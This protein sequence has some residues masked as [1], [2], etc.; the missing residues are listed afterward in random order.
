MI[1]TDA[2]V[3]WTAHSQRILLL[4]LGLMT[5]TT[6]SGCMWGRAM[7]IRFRDPMAGAP[8]LR[9]IN[10][11]QMEEI[12][13][14]LNQNTQRIRS[15]RANG[16]NIMVNRFPLSGTLA[17]EKGSHVRLV[18][19]SALGKEVDLGSNDERFWVWSRRMDPAFVTCRHENMETARQQLGIPFEPNW[20]M[21]ALGVEPLLAAGMK[22]EIDPSKRQARL[23]EEVTT[24]HG[25]P[26]RRTVLVDLKLGCVV[27]YSLYNYDG[28]RVALAR[29]SGHETT[30]GVVLP[31]RVLL[32][33]PQ[34]QM[35]MAMDLGKIQVNPHSIPSE[36]WQMPNSP[37]YTLVHLDAGVP[38][39][40]LGVRPESASHL[41]SMEME[42]SNEEFDE[43]AD[44]PSI[45]EF[46]RPLDRSGRARL[47]DE[48]VESDS[49]YT[50][51]DDWAR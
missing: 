47:L 19:S 35:A 37:D 17:V 16:V 28:A 24:A 32:D 15:W 42:P 7:G 3:R 31:H 13:A 25:R 2:A 51:D 1:S 27:E 21:Q 29:L 14:H 48:P 11:P 10:N 34:N 44:P 38:P 39:I 45:R 20:L 6:S 4:L 22:M 9:N 23:V 18:V 49:P 30:D 8:R 36:I 26:L 40:R 5:I 12:V 33:W 43:N 41:N 50:A 46:E